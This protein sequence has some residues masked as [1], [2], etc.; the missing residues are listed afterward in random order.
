MAERS[1]DDYVISYLTLR[2]AVG[3]LGIALPVVVLV[4]FRL[5][6]P[7]CDLPPSISHYFYTDVGPYFTGTL[8]AVALFMFSYKGPQKADRIAALIA[9]VCSLG[10]AFCPTNPDVHIGKECIKVTLQ[11]NDIRN[12]FHYGFAG[13]LFATFAF[14]SLVLFTKD[15]G[16]PTK[17]KKRR[18]TIYK[19]C[20]WGIIA[21]VLGIL[22][23]TI[24]D[25]T[26]DM[27]KETL[28]LTTYILETV[29]LVFFG[30]SWLV[31]GETIL[32]DE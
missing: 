13:V 32:K 10:I 6:N 5:L 22:A 4:G 23:S 7:T 17:N 9:C 8:C 20:G 24:F 2:K 14:F 15:R 11:A 31:K 30:L 16:H 3:I 12:A 1:Q 26:T 27:D 25:H 18:N 19:I 21:S 29:A 28:D